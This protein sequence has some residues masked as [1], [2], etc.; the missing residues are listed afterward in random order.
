MKVAKQIYGL[1]G[2]PIDEGEV[3]DNLNNNPILKLSL[4]DFL[5]AIFFIASQY[6]GLTDIK[7]KFLAP[8]RRNSEIHLL[9]NKAFKVFED[10]PVNYFSFLDWRRFH[11]NETRYTG[12]LRK[13]FGEYKYALYNQFLPVSF[14]FLRNAFEEYLRTQW[15]GGY[16]G[17]LKRLGDL[18]YPKKY[19]SRVE[20]QTELKMDFKGID[21][22]IERGKL[23]AVVQQQGKS[24]LIL[25][26]AVSVEELKRK[27]EDQISLKETARVLGISLQRVHDLITHG[28]LQPLRGPT[29]D[30]YK[31]WKF[32]YIQVKVFLDN[33]RTKIR[34]VT[35]TTAESVL[36]FADVLK[37][38]SKCKGFGVGRLVRLILD[39]EIVPCGE[40]QEVGLK[41]F[42]FSEYSVREY[43]RNQ[44]QGTNG[45]CFCITEAGKILGLERNVAYF[46]SSKGF[47]PAQKSSNNGWSILT[48]TKEDIEL[49]TSTYVI[50]KAETKQLRTTTR[51]LIRLLM[52]N[53]IIPVSGPIIDGGHLYLFNRCDLESVDLAALIAR[54]QEDI[55]SNVQKN[56]IV[57]QHQNLLY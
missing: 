7:G 38:F 54:V 46:L 48:V 42:L 28:C 31:K 47:I 16:V 50:L 36:S 15:S 27:F 8:S 17:S 18:P 10:W 19:L 22:L 53:G 3:K 26:D 51:R 21:N 49:F 25:I 40:V 2:L 1:C 4:E 39:G 14:D 34:G 29:I 52:Q 13:D 9:V 11:R 32:S 41:A 33:I 6:A 20:A 45:K 12:G 24:R 56:T 55:A 35:D 43:A 30:N 57:R 5:S 37:V 44:Q 23:K